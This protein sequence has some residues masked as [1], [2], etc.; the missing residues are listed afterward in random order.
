MYTARAGGPGQHRLLLEPELPPTAGRRPAR[1]S[2]GAS[3]L[4]T[5]AAPVVGCARAAAHRHPRRR[6]AEPRPPAGLRA[7]PRLL[8]PLCASRCARCASTRCT[9]GRRP[10]SCAT[11]A[12]ACWPPG[13]GAPSSSRSP[14]TARP[15]TR[16]PSRARLQE[17]LER[18]GAGVRHRR[19]ARARAG[20]A[21]RA[22]T[23]GS[24]SRALTLPHQLARVV[25]A[26]Q[27]FRAL[28]IARGETYH[29]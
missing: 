10:R 17:W 9:A 18:G 24:R 15:T 28:K 29:H 16:R 21:R 19:L 26:E 5:R 3:R 27:L 6:R 12:G 1:S 23:S 25:L 4:S 8:A 2:L 13:R 14:S 22:P 11:R 7:L 20:G